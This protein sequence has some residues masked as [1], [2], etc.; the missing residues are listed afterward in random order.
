MDRLLEFAGNHL[1]LVSLFFALL[2]LLI[3]NLSGGVIW[4]VQQVE[5][6]DL[7]RLINRDRA[8][9]L[10]VRPAEEYQGGHILNAINIPDAEL[11]ERQKEL[12]KARGKP[13]VAYCNNGGISRNTARRLK[14][15]GFENVQCLNGG[16]AAWRSAGLPVSREN[17]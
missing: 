16:L 4:G 5:P 12:E 3:W 17:G 9:V 13:L 15:L 6:S 8:V 7:T 1:F 10:D 2:I 11:A 14:A